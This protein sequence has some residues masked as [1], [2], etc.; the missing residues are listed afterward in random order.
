MSR[1]EVWVHTDTKIIRADTIRSVGWLS[2]DEPAVLELQVSGEKQPLTIRVQP[3]LPPYF[4]Y[5]KESGKEGGEQMREAQDAAWGRADGLD[6]GLLHA[7][8][9]A[10]TIPGGAAVFLDHDDHG[11]PKHWETEQLASNRPTPR[12]P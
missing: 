7:I 10:A 8:A 9:D 11:Y 3:D 12:E 6:Q 2:A 4:F 1:A 5:D